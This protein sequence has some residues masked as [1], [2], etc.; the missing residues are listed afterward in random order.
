MRKG[1]SLQPDS[2]LAQALNSS[3]VPR[4]L[5]E[6]THSAHPHDRIEGNSQRTPTRYR[7]HR[8]ARHKMAA[9]EEALAAQQNRL[10]IQQ[11]KT[12]EQADTPSGR[13]PW[14][15]SNSPRMRKPLREVSSPHMRMDSE[16]ALQK[17]QQQRKKAAC[18]AH[19]QQQHHTKRS[20]RR[21]GH[22]TVGGR[23]TPARARQN[24]PPQMFS[25]KKAQRG[26]R[27]SQHT[28]S[29]EE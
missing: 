22:Q 13:K 23:R 6:G 10:V 26:C 4:E 20:P 12:E 7:M 8:P 16:S 29:R 15:R 11:Q 5:D 2:T 19:K 14:R 1:K 9:K 21:S 27:P 17:L 24:A 25:Q 18:A 28:R 3:T